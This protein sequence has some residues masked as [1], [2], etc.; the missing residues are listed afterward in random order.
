MAGASMRVRQMDG[1]KLMTPP[2]QVM[3]VNQPHDPQ[4][5]LNL[6]QEASKVM[7]GQTPQPSS[8]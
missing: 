5:P 8:P 7:L 2:R 4:L 6:G 1:I 3:G